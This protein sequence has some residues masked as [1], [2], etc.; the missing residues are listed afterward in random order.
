MQNCDLSGWVAAAPDPKTRELR[1][2][3]HTI[4]YAISTSPHLHTQMLIKGGI[5]LVLRYQGSRFTRDIDFSTNQSF[6][7]FDEASFVSEFATS[8]ALAVEALPY[9]L[10]C[11]IQSTQVD[12]ARE[13]ATFK[14]FRV[15]V[16]HAYKR[17]RK[18]VHLMRNNCPDFVEL[19]YN[20]NEVTARTEELKISGGGTI[21]AY[22]FADLIAEKY[23]A[24]L[25][26]EVRNR[27]RRQDAY[28]LYRLLL[29]YPIRS[30]DEKRAI[31]TSLLAKAKS[32]NLS[33]DRSSISRAE[34][35]SRSSKEY[36]QLGSEI[37]GSLPSFDD[38]FQI[39]R[40]FYES[41]PWSDASVNA[42]QTLN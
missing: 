2:A 11:R 13:D 40:E 15:R 7:E 5:L 39:V 41:L 18:H 35:V 12:P 25:Q 31:L 34:I 16:G 32:R 20:F 8:L 23:R 21:Y 37:E 36:S 6:A 38:V 24:I 4:L 14:N 22:S 33:V 19:D 3:F 30:S 9:D 17:S 29:N 1:Q 42:E 10:D 28:D 26:Q 27:Y